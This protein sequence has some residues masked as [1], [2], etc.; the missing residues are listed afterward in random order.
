[1]LKD[2]VA[3][4]NS[5]LTLRG[6]VFF[7]L[8]LLLLV[9]ISSPLIVCSYEQEHKF[10]TI[11]EA[12]EGHRSLNENTS[13]NIKDDA[14]KNKSRNLNLSIGFKVDNSVEEEDPSTLLDAFG[15]MAKDILTHNIVSVYW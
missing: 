3:L 9:F 1:M 15:E 6:K 8:L 2:L 11:Y 7:N 5:S 14:S 10:S 4:E 13:D 12:A